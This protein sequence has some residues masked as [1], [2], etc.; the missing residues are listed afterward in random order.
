VSISKNKYGYKVD[1]AS[2]EHNIRFRRIV[3]SKKEALELESEVRQK[4]KQQT[5]TS[6]GIEEALERYLNG[7]AK[8]LKDYSGLKSKA[9]AILPFIK[10]KNFS[11]IGEV[12]GDIKADMLNA[13]LRPATINRRLALLRRIGNLSYQWGWIDNP[14]GNKVK[15]LSGETARHFYLTFDQVDDIAKLCPHTGG[16]ILAAAYTG[17]R[18]SELMGLTKAN[19]VDGFIVLDPDTKS[20]KP[21]A[22]PVPKQAEH[23][24]ELL[25]FPVTDYT[26]R[27]EFEAAREELGLEHIRFHDL[28]HT[29]A[30]FLAQA[31]ANLHLIGEAMGHSRPAMTARYAHLLRENLKDVTDKFSNLRR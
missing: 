3:G 13:G 18:K 28:R 27:K 5:I 6:R 31:G 19:I 25:P 12:A 23:A 7:E 30:S 24:F 10:G 1:V 26:V 16:M 14:V 8:N 29:Y 15:L 2:R 9:W 21:R 4:I 17:L 11:E 20:G 22:V